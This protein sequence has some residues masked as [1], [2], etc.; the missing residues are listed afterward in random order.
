MPVMCRRKIRT[1]KL[2]HRNRLKMEIRNQMRW[3]VLPLLVSSITARVL[4]ATTN[5]PPKEFFVSTNGNDSWSGRLSSPNGGGS[6][7]PFATLKRAIEA[8]RGPGKT[9]ETAYSS[10]N[11]TIRQGTYFLD[12]PLTLTLADSGVKIAAY[13]KEKPIISGGRLVSGWK[14]E[15]VNDKKAWVTEIS[16]VREGKWIFHELWVNGQRARPARRP[17]HG[18]LNVAEVP[19]A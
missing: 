2:E 14:E 13:Q 16:Q 3:I 1:T 10:T 15:M 7:G 9:D 19:D 17:N 6:D 5:L 8:A 18:Y 4:A 11:I 12:A